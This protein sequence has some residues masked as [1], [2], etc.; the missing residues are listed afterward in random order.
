MSDP[1]YNDIGKPIDRLIEEIGEVLQAWGK[2]QRFG[3][4]NVDPNADEDSTT[5]NLKDFI[6]ELN[7]LKCATAEVY[8]WAIKTGMKH[9]REEAKND[10]QEQR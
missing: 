2:I 10:Y 9:A 1:R 6:G 7:D 4:F 5:D 3:M 8:W